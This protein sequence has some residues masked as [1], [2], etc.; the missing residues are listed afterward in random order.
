VKAVSKEG[1]AHALWGFQLENNLKSCRHREACPE[2]P[3]ALKNNTRSCI[4]N[5]YVLGTDEAICIRRVSIGTSGCA[6]CF[7]GQRSQ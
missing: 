3:E 1:F 2:Q 4:S 6:D 5:F 7:T